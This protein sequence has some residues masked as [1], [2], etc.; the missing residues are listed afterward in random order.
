MVHV[1][2]LPDSSKMIHANQMIVL[3]TPHAMFLSF[4]V[5]FGRRWETFLLII[6]IECAM[7]LYVDL[8]C[9]NEIVEFTN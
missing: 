5:S 2:V 6:T 8:K 4:D 3:C 9:S 1:M 7:M